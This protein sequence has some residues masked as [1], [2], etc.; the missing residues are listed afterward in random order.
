MTVQRIDRKLFPVELSA[1]EKEML[2]FLST[3]SGK[4][5]GGV[6]RELLW[7][8]AQARHLRVMPRGT[9]PRDEKKG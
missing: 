3:D 7:R 9:V 4:P 1:V 2:S 6:L 5:M 8:E